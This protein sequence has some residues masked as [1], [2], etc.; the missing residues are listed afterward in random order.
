M[1]A[2]REPNGSVGEAIASSLNPVIFSSQCAAHA[3]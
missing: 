2:R 3:A 1:L